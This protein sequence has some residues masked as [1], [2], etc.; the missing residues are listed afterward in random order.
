MPSNDGR[1]EE[2]VR[3]GLELRRRGE[4]VL[5]G[6]LCRD[7]PE[8]TVELCRRLDAMPTGR[9]GDTFG[10][11]PSP[12][13]P[14]EAADLTAGSEPVPGYTLVHR[15]GRGGF[16][17]VWKASGPGGF[18]IALKFVT[19]ATKRVQVEQRSLDIIKTLRHPNLLTTFGSW[20][21]GGYLVIGMEL[22]DG[23]L[24]DKYRKFADRGLAGI[25]R[26]ALLEYLSQ[27]AA[28]I[29]FLN[30]PQDA[31]DGDERTGMQHR[32]IKPENILLSGNGAKVADF[33][34]VRLLEHTQTGHTGSLTPHYA[35]PE[36]FEGH[37]SQHSDQYSLAITYCQLRSGQVP[38][39]GSGAEIMR[40][41]LMGVPD[42]SMLPPEEQPV[43][44]RALSK[45]PTDRWPSCTAFVNALKAC[46]PEPRKVPRRPFPTRMAGLAILSAAV[47]LLV[48]AGISG[49]LRG[50]LPE[51]GMPADVTAQ[52]PS[53][54]ARQQAEQAEKSA[55]I[56]RQAYLSLVKDFAAAGQVTEA[57]SAATAWESANAALAN[58]E[59]KLAKVHFESARGLYEQATIQGLAAQ[60]ADLAARQKAEQPVSIATTMK[61]NP[62]PN[63]P[64]SV[65]PSPTPSSIPT[66]P[67]S[68][69][70]AGNEKEI[71]SKST[72][73]RLVLIPAGTFM[74]GSPDSEM[75]SS[76]ESEKYRPT[77]ESPQH[78]VKI[79]QAFYMG[80]HEVT[81]DEYEKVTGTNPSSHKE[82]PGENTRRFPVENVSWYE[83]VEFC[84]KLSL[85]DG[86]PAYYS[87]A[88]PPRNDGSIAPVNVVGGTGYRL[89]TEAE[90][91]YACRGDTTTPFHFGNMLNGDT[92]NVNGNYP[93]GT[94]TKG[95]FLQRT[96][97]VGSYEKN[98]FGLHD[99]HGN[100]YEWCEDPYDPDLYGR[101]TGTTIDPRPPSDL[102]TE[103]RVLR[104]G[105]WLY[106]AQGSR[107]AHRFNN[108]PNNRSIVIGFRV[109]RN[110]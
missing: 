24:L 102:E 11:V 20:Q 5:V 104:G 108:A 37:T 103:S 47:V 33:G 107:S 13:P 39:S 95:M 46:T 93:Y 75:L 3:K 21:T 99:M 9:R 52:K 96:T 58:T 54:E 34:L 70:A 17:E 30:G 62:K 100:V 18:S 89:P 44:A 28:G 27:A 29:D 51:R 57:E 60:K 90:W 91:E 15:L 48:I 86:L 41:H 73:M 110:K 4:P 101:R 50:F 68:T 61:E 49:Q 94:T 85:K 69:P 106:N 2:L 10:A 88:D 1:L 81:Q 66:T 77:N 7:C 84:N 67:T 92:A 14:T 59:F 78:S 16:G 72:G 32:D 56:A 74:M 80:V 38:F 6:E 19:M 12:D 64:P 97:T 22:A 65:V 105:S 23:T 63:T 87:L 76:A 26:D 109:A 53:A 35:A 79:S 43:V 82:V 36:F 42:L 98:G 45:Q 71:T 31:L 83:A 8:L 25:P 40:G 55:G